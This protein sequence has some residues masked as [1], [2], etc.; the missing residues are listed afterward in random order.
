MK[1]SK[2]ALASVL[3]LLLSTSIFASSDDDGDDKDYRDGKTVFK[4]VCVYCHTNKNIP[5]VLLVG[6][7]QHWSGLIEEG[8][9]FPTAHGWVGTRMMPRHGGEAKMT[10]PEFIN[11][12]AFMANESGADWNEYEDLDPKMYQEILKEIQIRYDRNELYDKI[13]KKY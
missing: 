2:F 1:K 5:N 11:A 9:Q 13:G 4:E 6:N 3:V 7:K 12:V 10:L 8:Q